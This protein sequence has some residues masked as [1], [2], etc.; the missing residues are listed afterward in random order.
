MQSF[1]LV[2]V[3]SDK[4]FTIGRKSDNSLVLD[5]LMVSRYHAVLER[6]QQKWFITNLTQNSVTQVN[7]KDVLPSTEASASRPVEIADGDVIQIG[8]HQLKVTFKGEALSL[9]LMESADQEISVAKTLTEKWTEITSDEV[10][11]PQGMSAR[12]CAGKIADQNCA[13]IKFK[14]ALTSAQGKS[15]KQ[16]NLSANEVLR[17]PS[18]EITYDGA[19]L[20]CK[21]RP[22][23]FDVNVENLDVFAGKK[24]LLHNVNFKLQAGEILAIIGRSG[25]GK[26]T[27]L[28]LLQGIHKSGDE[29]SVQIGSLDY[30][31]AEIRKHISFLEQDPELRKDLTVRETLL[32]GGR[33]YMNKQ[34]FKINATGRMEK[35]CELFG[36]SD[37][38]DNSVKT[39]SG[40]E[41]RRAALARELMGNP[42][43][44]VL[45]EPL[46]GLD[47]FNSKI[48]CSHLKQ[49]SFLGHTIILTTHSYEALEIAN[50]VLV[51]HQGEQGFFGSP[52]EAYHYFETSDPEKILSSLNDETSSN[53]QKVFEEKK[54]Q[55][56]MATHVTAA[57]QKTDNKINFCFPKTELSPMFLYKV[58]LTAKQWFRDKGK[59]I[60]LLAQPLVIGFLFS[61]IF[62]S[63]TSLWIVAF[64]IILSANWLALSLSIREIVQEKEI[65]RNEFRKGVSVV[66]T[67]TAKLFLPTL[68][69][70][71]QTLIVYLFV[72]IRTQVHVS[73]APLLLTV[74][75]MVIPP[76]TVGLTVSAFAKNAGQANA[77]LPLLIIPQVALAGALVPLDQM[78]PTGRVLSNVIWARFNQNSLLNLLLE[79]QDPIE[80]ILAALAIA[81]G[82]YIVMVIRIHCSTKAK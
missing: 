42:G 18:C 53:W 36:L 48:L 35:F 76:V 29:S 38:M 2:N 22:H 27:L 40:G 80:N 5:N 49:L 55:E 17:L 34:D 45:D 82:C 47:P 23:G 44:I 11:I 62:S 15:I 71:L 24:Q 59:F 65:L 37:R 68:V 43:L 41:S 25:Q 12:I 10:D 31:N 46:S 70:W 1:R 67:V 39:L 4:P 64:A 3:E 78:L 20:V 57:I 14:K 6:V 63:L 16:M 73:P 21:N 81:L 60:A 26:S 19:A 74:A 54:I 32:D 30:R 66:T 58:M 72:S 13:V 33:V 52:Q 7:G 61:Q 79:R 28:R 77:L 75:A 8:P 51:L 50:K 56:T 69:A 9:L